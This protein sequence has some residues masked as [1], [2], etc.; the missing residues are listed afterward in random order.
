MP[1]RIVSIR[2]SNYSLQIRQL[3]ECANINAKQAGALNVKC[4]LSAGIGIKYHGYKY[5]L[6]I[7]SAF[8]HLDL[9]RMKFF[10]LLSTHI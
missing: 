10:M 1:V 2:R 8:I 9:L 5:K 6:Y 4:I 3:D 7:K